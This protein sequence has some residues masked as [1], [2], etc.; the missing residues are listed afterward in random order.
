MWK[1]FGSLDQENIL[2][3]LLNIPVFERKKMIF[4]FSALYDRWT[5]EVSMDELYEYNSISQ[6]Y[7]DLKGVVTQFQ[8]HMESR[9]GPMS[10]YVM[11]FGIR[12]L[13]CARMT[14][15]SNSALLCSSAWL[16]RRSKVSS[17]DSSLDWTSV[18]NSLLEIRNALAIRLKNAVR[19]FF[20]QITYS[21]VPKFIIFLIIKPIR[22][23]LFYENSKNTFTVNN[24][25]R[26]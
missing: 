20:M 7:S 9:C 2:R 16:L 23:G 14:L 6:Y 19:L 4:Y 25:Y 11:L 22:K 21:R 18:L 5:S 17:R 1:L 24:F 13:Y 8:G 3:L 15:P 12:S 26:I 10:S